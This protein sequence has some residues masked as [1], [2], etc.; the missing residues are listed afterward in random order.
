MFAQ[1]MLKLLLQSMCITKLGRVVFLQVQVKW[2][3]QRGVALTLSP[4]DRKT[5]KDA[6]QIWGFSLRD[7]D[8][9]ALDKLNK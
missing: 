1:A 6:D 3:L 9:E 7:S 8:K 2:V 4:E 5:M